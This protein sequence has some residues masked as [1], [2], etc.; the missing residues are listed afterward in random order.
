[1]ARR[2]SQGLQ[3]TLI[4]FVILTIMLLVTTIVFW[5]RAKTLTA[6]N[7]SLQTANAEAQAAATTALDGLGKLKVWLGHTAQTSVEDIEAQYNRD[8]ATYAK[9]A[10]EVQRTYK[11]VPVLLFSAIQARN[12][13]ILAAA[14]GPGGFRQ[15]QVGTRSG[16][17]GCS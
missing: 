4:V 10:P 7:E 15:D 3:I 14:S 6:D 13:T 17:G 1:M 2:E 8:M 5:N 9:S 11:D 16:R 12:K